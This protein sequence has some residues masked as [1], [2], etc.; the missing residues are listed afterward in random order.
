ML[1]TYRRS[2]SY[3]QTFDLPL[4]FD[5]VDHISSSTGEKFSE[6]LNQRLFG[7][8]LLFYLLFKLYSVVKN[9]Q[10]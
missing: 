3:Q 8:L 9:R 1:N 2:N 4:T 10:N 5:D 6:L 7:N